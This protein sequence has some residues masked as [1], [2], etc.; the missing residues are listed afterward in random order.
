MTLTVA[1]FN[2]LNLFDADH[3]AKIRTLAEHIVAARPDVV[4]LQEVGSEDAL[5]RLAY[6]LRV[7]GL[8]LEHMLVGAA[9]HRGI[10]NAVLSSRPFVEA[11]TH[12]SHSLPFPTFADGDPEPFPNRLTVRRAIAEVRVLTPRGATVCIYVVHWKSKRLEAKRDANGLPI[13]AATARDLGES[14][15]RSLLVRSAEALFVRGLVDEAFD[16]GDLACVLGD[17][18]DTID[19]LPVRLLVGR[20]VDVGSQTMLVSVLAKVAQPRRFSIL[21]RG[22]RQLIDHIFASPELASC[23]VDSE[24][25][26]QQ[27]R[28]HGLPNAQP[29]VPED[30]DH[31]LVWAM[32]DI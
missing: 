14:E 28:D 7:R 25:R 13:P 20:N 22:E 18:N 31:A 5:D 16:R 9:D 2:L 27:L 23:L 11:R 12:T 19:S 8:L 15:M 21:N 17:F 10:R 4:G 6:A 26:N 3:D 30:S 24:I 32:F 29:G 1:S